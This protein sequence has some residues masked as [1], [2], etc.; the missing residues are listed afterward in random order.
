MGRRIAL[1]TAFNQAGT[2]IIEKPATLE[3]RVAALQRQLEELAAAFHAVNSI[4]IKDKRQSERTQ[5]VTPSITLNTNSTNY[6]GIPIG[7]S[8]LGF[9][10]RGGIDVLTVKIDGYYLGIRR[11]ETLSAAAE[12]S[13]GVRRSGWTYWKIHDGRTVKEVFGRQNG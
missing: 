6:D 5:R 11:F 9:S 1:G 2:V 12:A 13:S 3:E 7:T 4:R 10:T 8:L